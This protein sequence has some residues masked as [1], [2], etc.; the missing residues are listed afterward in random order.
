[1]NWRYTAVPA[2]D[3]TLLI[4]IRD[5]HLRAI[6]LSDHVEPSFSNELNITE[7]QSQQNGVSPCLRCV[8][9]LSRCAMV[10]RWLWLL[11]LRCGRES[12]HLKTDAKTAAHVRHVFGSCTETRGKGK[13]NIRVNVP[14]T[15][16][17]DITMCLTI[18]FH[19]VK[20]MWPRSP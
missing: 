18:F 10:C 6:V 20:M 3:T 17:V 14:K 8:T 1:M 5:G 2:K 13:Q 19:S 12:C 15:L 7:A 11:R 4:H 9:A 16:S